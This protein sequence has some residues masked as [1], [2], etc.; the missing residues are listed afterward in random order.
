M[1]VERWCSEKMNF[2]RDGG[3]INS[4]PLLYYTVQRNTWIIRSLHDLS[5]HG[6]QTDLMVHMLRSK[7]LGS[8]G[9]KGYRSEL[10]N[11]ESIVLTQG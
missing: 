2:W 7:R 11:S 4:Y 6:S 8:G 9:D 10:A 1:I 3:E 5:Q